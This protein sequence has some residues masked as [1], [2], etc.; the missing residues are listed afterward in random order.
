MEIDELIRRVAGEAE[1]AIVR[2]V[3]IA[4][5]AAL[6]KAGGPGGQLLT[7]FLAAPG[8]R[9]EQREVR[10]RHILGSG[11]SQQAIETW[12]R[13]HPA[14]PLPAD[15]RQLVTRINGIHLWANADTGRSYQ[16]LTPV[17]E[18]ELARMKMYGSTAD[19]G[20]LDDRYVALSYHQDESCYVVL[21]LLSGKYFLMD[22]AG[23]DVS[24]PIADNVDELL[25]WLW[26]HRLEPKS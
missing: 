19:S 20:L 21:D 23:A 13:T 26:R 5:A 24:A 12:Q 22:T 15:L 14:H 1:R 10:Y 7:E 4:P 25:D 6:A 17:E 8:R 16:G 11:A 2:T 9:S 18:W 3:W